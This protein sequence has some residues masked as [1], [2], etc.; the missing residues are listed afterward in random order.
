M[1]S[2]VLTAALLAVSPQPQSTGSGDEPKVETVT[3]RDTIEF[4]SAMRPA[5]D[6]YK[7]CLGAGL[8][9]RVNP[10]AGGGRAPVDFDTLAASVIAECKPV[11]AASFAAAQKSL[12]GDPKPSADRHAGVINRA[13]ADLEASFTNFVKKVRGVA[14]GTPQDAA[15]PAAPVK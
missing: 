14:E 11:R 8:D 5:V 6:T 7:E 1:L 4:P 15:P 2:I 13:F 12:D 3:A 10:N 9:K